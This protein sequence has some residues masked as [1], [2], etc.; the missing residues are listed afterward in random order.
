MLSG[1]ADVGMTEGPE[2]G[3]TAQSGR[4]PPEGQVRKRP[5]PPGWRKPVRFRPLPPTDKNSDYMSDNY[6]TGRVV[7]ITPPICYESRNGKT[8]TRRDLTV[9]VCDADAAGKAVNVDEGN[10]P[11]FSFFGAAG[12]DLDRYRPGQMVKVMFE[13]VGRQWTDSEG[14]KRTA[15][16]V[17]AKRVIGYDGA[18]G[19]WRH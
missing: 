3:E 9:E 16:D 15:N 13:L 5:H 8:Y 7:E 19:A 14:R 18:R 10:R 2:L 6:I 12:R 4:A 1:V 17:R 11:T